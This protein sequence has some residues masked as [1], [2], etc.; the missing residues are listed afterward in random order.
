MRVLIAVLASAVSVSLATMFAT[1]AT[2]DAPTLDIHT[3]AKSAIAYYQLTATIR[4][5]VVAADVS[6]YNDE[7]KRYFA[8]VGIEEQPACL[9][10]CLLPNLP[11]LAAGAEFDSPQLH[12]SVNRATLD[13]TLPVLYCA[14]SSCPTAI[15]VSLVWEPDGEPF[16]N[17]N[18]SRTDTKQ[19]QFTKV[20]RFAYADA[21]ATGFV[22]D[23]TADLAIGESSGGNLLEASTR[24]V[25]Y[26]D[27]GVCLG[28]L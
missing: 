28:P 18:S 17:S 26:G 19:C 13:V 8:S 15:H 10:D 25:G 4:L 23:G 16:R 22:S 24:A 1:T 27:P 20:R 5:S 21:T 14:L 9:P 7:R 2:A 6:G 11:L 3:S 12:G